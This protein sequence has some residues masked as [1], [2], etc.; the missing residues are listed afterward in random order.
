MRRNSSNKSINDLPDDD[1]YKE[2]RTRLKRIETKKSTRSGR[3]VVHKYVQDDR[4]I[5]AATRYTSVAN[6]ANSLDLDISHWVAEYE[7]GKANL[8][9]LVKDIGRFLQVTD[10]EAVQIIGNIVRSLDKFI[11]LIPDRARWKNERQFHPYFIR[12][13]LNECSDRLGVLSNFFPAHI[14]A[15]RA[16]VASSEVV[17]ID[18]HYKLL[19]DIERRVREFLPNLPSIFSLPEAARQAIEDE[20]GR[21][22]SYQ[23]AVVDILNDYYETSPGLAESIDDFYL[24]E[25]TDATQ[26]NQYVVHSSMRRKFPTF[27]PKHYKSV[28]TSIYEVLI[29]LFLDDLVHTDKI[30]AAVKP[31]AHKHKLALDV[32]RAVN[33]S[34]TND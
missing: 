32:L 18:K 29:P 3:P 26:Y 5:K 19:L 13:A 7:K 34:S 27:W 15:S 6:L 30:A 4:Q 12:K 9:Y 10:D 22:G 16:K 33:I 17:S 14:A 8:D 24:S 20:C 1:K 31:L 2:R 21:S 23:H 28:P 11:S 25:I